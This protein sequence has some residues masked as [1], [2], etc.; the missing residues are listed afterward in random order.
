LLKRFIKVKAIKADIILDNHEYSLNEYGIN[1]RIISTPG[2]TAG[3]VSVL[4]NSGEAFVGCLAHNRL[5]FTLHPSLPIYAD[6]VEQIK[7]SW[8]KIINEGAEIIYPAHGKPF[9]VELIKKYIY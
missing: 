3:S 1:G 5:P 7:Q 2:H 9:P 6:N 4:L 8:K